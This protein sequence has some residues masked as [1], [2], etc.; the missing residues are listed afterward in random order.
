MAESSGGEDLDWK[1][2]YNLQSEVII[3]AGKV[4]HL[5][6]KVRFVDLGDARIGTVLLLHGIPTWSYLYQ[7]AISEFVF[8]GYRV[9]APDF[10]GYGFSDRRD[11]FDRSF[12]DQVKVIL[13]L[14]QMLDVNKVSVVGHDIG[15][16]VALILAIEHQKLIDKLVLSNIVCYDRFDDDML[17]FGHPLRWKSRSV[18]EL[19]A[20]MDV[21]LDLGFSDKTK[22]TDKFCS[23][24]KAPL[25]SEEGKLS[26][27]RNASALN[28][29]QTMALV[30]RHKLVT[31]PTLILWGAED[32]WQKFEDAQ[33][34]ATEIP[35]SQLVSLEKTSHWVPQDN[36][37]AFVSE[38]LK[39]LGT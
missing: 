28:A 12:Q 3:P 35:N 13:T 24:I 32:I 2:F 39:F 5:D 18:D 10:I 27:M 20:V 34:L 6:L 15:G 14:L 31:S 17:D 23:G 29:N 21:S 22:K 36:H 9:I 26:L 16:S 30:E 25:A 7:K 11:G 38:I 8:N 19:L 33:R 37:R 4:N 1:T